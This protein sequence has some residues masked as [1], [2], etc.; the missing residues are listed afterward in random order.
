MRR[1]ALQSGTLLQPR[2]SFGE[3]AGKFLGPSTGEGN[4]EERRAPARRWA[5]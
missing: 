5:M 1:R 4:G 2:L 3:V